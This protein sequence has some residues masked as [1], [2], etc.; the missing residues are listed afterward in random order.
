MRHASTHTQHALSPS[1][2]PWLRFLTPGFL[3]HISNYIFSSSLYTGENQLGQYV[4]TWIASDTTEKFTGDLSP[5][6][7]GVV[8]L[9][10]TNAKTPS[11]SD[12]LGY[13]S[14]GSEAYS[15]DREVTFHVPELAVDIQM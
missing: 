12:Y 1:S 8:D 4:L 15:S 2:I 13:M 9:Q 11:D 6:I 7:N 3:R 10:V 14:M 5:L